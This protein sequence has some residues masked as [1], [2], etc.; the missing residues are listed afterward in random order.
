MTLQGRH[1]TPSGDPDGAAHVASEPSLQPLYERIAANTCTQHGLGE[2]GRE[3]HIAAIVA[4]L[5]E[6]G[7]K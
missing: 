7:H 3:Q 6:L 2:N 5:W 4:H 1:Q